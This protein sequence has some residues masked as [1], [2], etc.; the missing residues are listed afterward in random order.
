MLK[1]SVITAVYN[2]CETIRQTLD[3]V[4]SQNYP[5]VEYIVID[6]SSTD[7]TLQ[8]LES[9]KLKI[10]VLISEPDGG[11]YHALNKGILHSSG[12]IVGFLHADDIFEGSDVLEKIASA[13]NAAGVEAVYGD[14]VY[15]KRNNTSKILRYWKSCLFNDQL[16]VQ[17]WMP[18]HPTLYVKR[19][20]YHR[21]GMFNT[22]YRI[23]ADYD[24]V[25]RFFGK[26]KLQSAYLPQVL[27]RMRNGGISNKSIKTIFKKSIE[28]ISALKRNQIG[29]IFILFR[30]NLLKL[31]QFIPNQIRKRL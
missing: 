9:Y 2:N 13:F 30:K 22:M 10:D 11:I 28:D 12:D 3:S 16:L 21:L 25:L 1:I 27:V 4:L 7:G 26:G 5:M 19:S 8:V 24:L 6:G 31:E 14:L 29:G 17:G 20:V 18:P 23:A 15:V